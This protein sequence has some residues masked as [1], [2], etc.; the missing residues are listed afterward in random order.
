[1]LCY[2]QE[3]HKVK[4]S[5]DILAELWDN[6]S[7]YTVLVGDELNF[8]PEVQCHEFSDDWSW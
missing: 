3:Q 4:K 8:C 1:M 6:A 2:V 7:R 5:E